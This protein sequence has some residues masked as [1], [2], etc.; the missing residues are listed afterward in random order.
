MKGPTPRPLA[1]G[2]KLNLNF[3]MDA[4]LRSRILILCAKEDISMSEM[5]R[6]A[7]A[8]YLARRE[9]NI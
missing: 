2:K 9:G 3:E 8:D 4:T 1:P 7:V 5:C 6:R